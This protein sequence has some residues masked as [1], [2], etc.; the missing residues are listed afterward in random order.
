MWALGPTLQLQQDVGCVG[1]WRTL[2]WRVW[3]R[4]VSPAWQ[5]GG[6]DLDCLAYPDQFAAVLRRLHS[7]KK[8]HYH[9][10][11]SVSES[12]SSYGKAT[13][14]KYEKLAG[15]SFTRKYLAQHGVCNEGV[16]FNDLL[17]MLL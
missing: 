9:G 2:F 11:G 12:D 5:M 16:I 6:R 4:A 17:Q 13:R 15:K 10:L 14:R 3:R 7:L 1:V 8:K